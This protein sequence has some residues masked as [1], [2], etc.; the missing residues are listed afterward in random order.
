MEYSGE[1]RSVHVSGFV[2]AVGLPNAGKSTLVNRFL[3]EKISI[4]TPKPQTTRTNV[5]C[6]L[7]T[8]DYQVVFIDTPGLLKPRYRMQE[9]M[10]SFITNAV[11]GADIILVIIDSSRGEGS[12]HPRLVSFADEIGSK[13]TVVAL[14]K[15]DLVRKHMLLGIIAKTH[16]LFPSA[17]IVP[18][19]ATD[20]D[21]A[22]ELFSVILSRL[23]EGPSYFPEDMISSESERFFASELIREA[24]FL[25]MEEEIPY[26]SA[27]AID[28]YE[29]KPE[30][31]I[32]S[33]SILVEKDSQKPILI[34]KG[35][36]TI[37]DI[38]TRARLGIEEFLGTKV[39]LELRVKVRKD[40]RDKDVYLREVGL[41]KER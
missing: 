8:E 3:R 23:P 1:K 34:G 38:G 18:V 10:A 30:L 2:A 27:V 15:I 12:F 35:G 39:F 26:A 7:S 16:D 25:T 22:D 21:G 5:T 37:K 28:Q 36:R 24:V 17:E 6:I 40:W 33:A 29:E 32:I 13:M 31:V 19:S 14:N 41:L 11:A 4:V 9:V 20:G